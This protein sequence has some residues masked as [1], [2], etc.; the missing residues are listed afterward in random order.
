MCT[1]FLRR[2]DG[3]GYRKMGTAKCLGFV[4]HLGHWYVFVCVAGVA[5]CQSKRLCSGA[6]TST[7][8]WHYVLRSSITP[9]A[10]PQLLL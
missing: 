8:S 1:S 5:A 7:S 2:N 3:R 9:L 4:P 6:S 10:L